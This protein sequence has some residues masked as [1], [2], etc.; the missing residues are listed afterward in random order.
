[1]SEYFIFYVMQSKR[2]KNIYFE[3]EIVNLEKMDSKTIQDKERELIE[4]HNG[5]YYI[6]ILNILRLD[7]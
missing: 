3:N 2:S 7:E 5:G 4:R 1:M 6:T